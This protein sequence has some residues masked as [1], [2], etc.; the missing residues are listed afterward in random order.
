MGCAHGYQMSF[1]AFAASPPKFIFEGS[2]LGRKVGEERG[3][4]RGGGGGARVGGG[5]KKRGWRVTFE[6]DC[7]GLVPQL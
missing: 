3:E 6:A 5:G 2:L 1:H 7:S 4:G